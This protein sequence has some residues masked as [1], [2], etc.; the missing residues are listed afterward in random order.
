MIDIINVIEGIIF[1]EMQF[2]DG[3]ELVLG[4]LSQLVTYLPYMVPDALHQGGFISGGKQTEVHFGYCEVSGNVD[5]GD[6][7]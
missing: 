5:L 4:M 3:P 1:Q 6:C 2:G 7:D